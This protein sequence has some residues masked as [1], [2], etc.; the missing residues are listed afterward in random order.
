MRGVKTSG[1]HRWKRAVIFAVL[2]LVFGVLLNS[3]YKVY[4]KKNNAEEALARMQAELQELEERR[5]FLTDS[6]TKLATEEGLKFEI[7][8]KLNMAEVGESIAIIVEEE[9]E[10][11]ESGFSASAWQ[12]L[13][14]LFKNLFD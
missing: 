7:K 13:K 2:L 8:K 9:N 11:A 1:D 12:K 6:L 4:Q 10:P 14:D 3:V 5:S